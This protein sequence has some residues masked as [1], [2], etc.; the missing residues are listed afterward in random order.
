MKEVTGPII[1]TALVLCAVFVPT[2]F[3]SGLSGQFYK[4]FALTIAISTV[5]SAFNSLTLSPALS[6]LLLKAHDA[7]P[8]R[9]TRILNALFGWFFRPFNRFFTRASNGYVRGVGRVLR[10]SSIA[11]FVYVGL[12][13]LT[14]FGFSQH[15]DRLRAGAGQAVSGRLRA[16]ARCGDARSHRSRHQAHDRHRAED[17]GRRIGAG[18]SGPFDQRL[19]ERAE[20]RHRVHAAEAVRGAPRRVAVGR[21]HRDG[22]EPAVRADPGRLHRDLPAAAGAGPRH[23]RRLQAADRGSRQLRRERALQ[24]AAERDREGERSGPS[25][26]ACSPA[27]RST[28]R[29]STSTSIARRRRPRACRCRISTTR[30]RCIS[31]RST[32][33]TST[34]SAAPTRSTR[35]PSRAFA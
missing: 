31:A 11:L 14:A 12:I 2:A 3:I 5:I 15:A 18:V 17:A 26:P 7:P 8:D 22:A 16:A 13:G 34:A 10:A 33:T 4:Q 27:S 20:L 24:A 1:A 28:C 29:R 25:S 19:H 9:L 6:A 32:S 23:D 30:C 21:R 35:R